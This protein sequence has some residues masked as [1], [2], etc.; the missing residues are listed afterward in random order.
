MQRRERDGNNGDL[1]E[2]L[3]WSEVSTHTGIISSLAVWGE[4]TQITQ[5]VRWTLQTLI[6]FLSTIFSPC[7]LLRLAGEKQLKRP[8]IKGHS[9][10]RIMR[11][12]KFTRAQSQVGTTTQEVSKKKTKNNKIL[13]HSLQ[14]VIQPN[15]NM[16]GVF[17]LPVASCMSIFKKVPNARDAWDWYLEIGVGAI[18]A[19]LKW[20]DWIRLCFSQAK[21]HVPVV[22]MLLF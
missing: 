17:V 7:S 12:G 13:E 5:M 3:V 18:H 14:G 8:R 2:F 9:I 10:C 6:P 11:V 4:Q 20:S 15:P 19:C 1:Q 21:N 16:P 22:S